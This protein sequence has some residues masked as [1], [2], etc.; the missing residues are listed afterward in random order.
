M[1]V[2]LDAHTKSYVQDLFQSLEN[3]VKI[4]VFIGENRCLFCNETV[5]I[6][7]ILKDLA[8]DGKIIT[9]ITNMDKE[10]EKAEKF[11]IDKYPAI[12]IHGKEEYNIRYF[13][14]P[15][16]YEFSSLVE[17]IVDASSGTVRI[18]KDVEETIKQI[19]Q[20]VHIQVFVTPTCP[21]C[22]R[23]VRTAHRFAILNKN[24]TG[25]MIEAQEFPEL[26]DQYGVYAVPKVVI[27]DKVSFEGALPEQHFMKK[28]LEALN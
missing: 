6:V 5:E 13:G 22:P 19:N 1:V 26:S 18:S 16:G 27:N 8:P 28:V 25:D 3:P 15:S 11:G 14:I 17:D 23:A 10:P 12:L 7:N 9:E 20:K 2:E 24:I 4:Y 21:Y